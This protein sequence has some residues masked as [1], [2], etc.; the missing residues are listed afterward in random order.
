MFACR[1]VVKEVRGDLIRSGTQPNGVEGNV[2]SMG[3]L[4]ETTGI[5]SI[6]LIE[7]TSRSIGAV[8]NP[9]GQQNLPPDGF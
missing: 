3:C 8:G 2:G 1:L 6:R 9:I 7:V 4:G 5:G